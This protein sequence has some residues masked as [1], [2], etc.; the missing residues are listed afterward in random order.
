M[1]KKDFL[2]MIIGTIILAVILKSNS[3]FLDAYDFDFVKN[4]ILVL[5]F[6][7]NALY[8]FIVGILLVKFLR[9]KNT[10]PLFLSIIPIL[11]FIVVG[12]FIGNIE[13]NI[14]LFISSFGI[15]SLIVFTQIIFIV[16]GGMIGIKYFWPNTQ[17]PNKPL[18]SGTQQSG[19]P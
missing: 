12:I 8:P 2:V 3:Y 10:E 11:N 5:T 17:P 14:G 13:E 15:F 1:S 4:N 6:L 19:A 7:W 16:A 18:K 9:K